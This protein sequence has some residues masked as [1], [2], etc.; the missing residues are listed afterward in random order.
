MVRLHRHPPKPA[1]SMQSPETLSTETIVRDRKSAERFVRIFFP[2]HVTDKNKSRAQAHERVVS[3]EGLVVISNHIALRDGP[4]IFIS[5]PAQDEVMIAKP[6][7]SPIADHQYLVVAFL[8]RLLRAHINLK[9]VVTPDT[10]D[11]YPNRELGKG[12]IPYIRASKETLSEGGILVIFPQVMRKDHLGQPDET[13][14]AMSTLIE[15][16]T[17]IHQTNFSVLPMGFGLPEGTDYSK[18]TGL[19]MFTT[20]DVSIGKLWSYQAMIDDAANAKISL[21]TW[22]FDQLRPL[23]PV[24]H[25]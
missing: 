16:M 19:N 10:K 7:T 13:M 1:S 9:P 11:K 24:S 2:T 14:T 3:G 17:K 5:V 8:N 21:D 25:R 12:F 23:V 15:F 20:Y 4:Q 22:A 6:W 18:A